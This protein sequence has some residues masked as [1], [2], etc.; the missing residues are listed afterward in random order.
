MRGNSHLKKLFLDK[1][2]KMLHFIYDSFFLFKVCRV[3]FYKIVGNIVKV[4]TDFE[5]KGDF[6]QNPSTLKDVWLRGIY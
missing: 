2:K 6:V 4:M 3:C 1:D 5:G